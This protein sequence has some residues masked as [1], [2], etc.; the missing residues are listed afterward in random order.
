MSGES[1]AGPRNEL[2]L[3]AAGWL[4]LYAAR[5]R[6]AGAPYSGTGTGQADAFLVMMIVHILLFCIQRESR[7]GTNALAPTCICIFCIFCIAKWLKAPQAPHS[8]S[9]RS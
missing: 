5:L 4:L 8:T 7:I 1:C 6:R 9:T 2:V 3:L